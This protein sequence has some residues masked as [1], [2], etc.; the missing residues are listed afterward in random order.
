VAKELSNT[1]LVIL[2]LNTSFHMNRKTAQISNG[3][4]IVK[5]SLIT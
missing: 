1:G 2:D 3:V 5:M 4:T